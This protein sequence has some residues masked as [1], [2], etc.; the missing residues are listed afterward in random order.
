MKKRRYRTIR[1]LGIL[2]LGIYLLVPL[3]LTDRE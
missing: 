2:V 3:L 1:A